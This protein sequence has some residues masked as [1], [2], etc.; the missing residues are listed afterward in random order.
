MALQK[1]SRQ[2]SLTFEL[3]CLFVSNQP[4]IADLQLFEDVVNVTLHRIPW[5]ISYV[6]RVWW[7]C[8]QFPLLPGAAGAPT[9]SSGPEK[10]EE[11]EVRSTLQWLVTT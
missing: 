1:L 6:C 8:W 9:A 10:D 5:Q 4:D 11:T 2:T 3:V 7:L